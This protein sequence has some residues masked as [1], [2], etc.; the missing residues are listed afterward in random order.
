MVFVMQEP[1]GGLSINGVL[2]AIRRNRFKAGITFLVTLA[3]TVLVIL[4]APRKYYSRSKAI[5]ATW[6]L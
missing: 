6:A 2:A 5:R 1:S 4:L 3:L